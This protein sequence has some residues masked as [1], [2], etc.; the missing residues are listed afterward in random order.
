[1]KKS[2]IMAAA[3]GLLGGCGDDGSN[4]DAQIEFRAEV[5][6]VDFACDELYEGLGADESALRFAD[7]RLYLHEVLLQ[8]EQGDWV[9]VELED[10]NFQG[11][12]VVLLDFEDCAE[13]ETWTTVLGTLPAGDYEGLRFTMGIPFELNHQNKDIAQPPLNLSTMHWNWQGGYK[14]LRVDSGVGSLEDA[15]W[16]MHL[17]STDCDGD[18]ISGGTTDCTNPNRVLVEFDGFRLEENIVVADLARLVDGAELGSNQ[19]GTPV[20][21]MAAPADS[22]CG[23]IFANLGLPFGDADA[24]SPQTFFTLE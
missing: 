21:C 9:P 2:L 18:P 8:N 19:D 12:G 20:G 23:P 3:L 14:F 1:M 10:A 6:G 15:D 5:N 13:P 11:D 24:P 7:F 16:R 17:G 22:D 4:I